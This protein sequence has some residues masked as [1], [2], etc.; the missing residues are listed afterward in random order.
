MTPLLKMT[1]FSCLIENIV[2]NFICFIL[3]MLKAFSIVHAGIIIGFS[4]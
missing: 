4:F 2:N 3:Y 1:Y